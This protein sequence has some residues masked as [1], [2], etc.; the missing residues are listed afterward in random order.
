MVYLAHIRTAFALSNRTYGGPRMHRDLANKA[1]RRALV[2]RNPAPGPV[3]HSDSGVQYC[4]VDYQALPRKRGILISLSAIITDRLPA[5]DERAR[6]LL[7]QLDGRD[8]LQDHQD[9]ADLPSR[10]ADLPAGRKR[11]RQIQRLA[12]RA[13]SPSTERSAK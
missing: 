5:T 9:C 8:V 2:A 6:V 12:S 1:L 4:S 3:H 11:G 13:P 10:P 7:R